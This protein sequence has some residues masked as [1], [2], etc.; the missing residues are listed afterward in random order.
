MVEAPIRQLVA[1]AGV[2]AYIVVA[3]VKKNK[4]S[5]GYN[6]ATQEYVDLVKDGVIDPTKVVR[7]ALQNAAS[8]ASL[9]LTTEAAITDLPEKKDAM[10]GMPGGMPGMDGGMGMG[11]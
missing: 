2:D 3:E 1:N 6:V 8:A 5:Y 4:G 7:S 9:F 10:A 11:M